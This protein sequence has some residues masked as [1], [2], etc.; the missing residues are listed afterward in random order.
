MQR[1]VLFDFD[2]TIAD[3]LHEVLATY[4]AL[5]PSLSVPVVRPEDVP[6]LR[7]LEPREAMRTMGV[8]FFKLPRI[9][10][11]VRGALRERGYVAQP[12]A[13]MPHA[14]EALEAQGIRTGVVSSNAEANIRRFFEH[15]GLR[16]PSILSGGVSLFGKA[17]RLGKVMAEHGLTAEGV[18]YV[19]DEVRDIEAGKKAR[20]R[21]VAVSWGYGAEDALH[22][23]APD[24]LV[25]SPQELIGVLAAS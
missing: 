21:T 17:S 15:H 14:L 19:G 16:A 1:A 10:T 4:N 9:L 25:R 7:A 8:P 12:F 22:A 24:A 20:V 13:G 6:V 5:A 2:G 11:T 3:S 23:A 18:T